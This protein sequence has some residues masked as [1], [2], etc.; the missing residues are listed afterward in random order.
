MP[1]GNKE[2]LVSRYS[3][4]YSYLTD[5]EPDKIKELG[6]QVTD[7]IFQRTG[8]TPPTDPKAAPAMLRGIWCDKIYY[9]LIPYQKG[10]S[11]EEK[12][13]RRD[14][15]DKADDLINKIAD[16]KII[17][18]DASGTAVVTGTAPISIV[19]T[20]RITGVL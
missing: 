3:D 5:I 10:L 6:A 16:G 12:A 11:D 4:A 7:E 9:K 14:I 17:I 13:R 18:K 2:I 1:F 19:A 15:A 8:I 20:K